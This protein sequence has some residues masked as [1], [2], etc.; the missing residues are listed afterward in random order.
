VGLQLVST[1][2]RG[3]CGRQRKAVGWPGNITGKRGCGLYCGYERRQ[4]CGGLGGRSC[5]LNPRP[6]RRASA[7]LN[8][9]L[10]TQH[11][12]VETLARGT[13]KPLVLS[14]RDGPITRPAGAAPALA[15]ALAVARSLTQYHWQCPWRR[16]CWVLYSTTRRV[17]GSAE[18]CVGTMI[19]VRYGVF[20]GCD[21]TV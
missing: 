13:T 4:R 12:T 5:K 2:A 3:H 19:P 20:H 15:V 7:C 8:V 16:G 21:S 17:N 1:R 10:Q 18:G 9:R 11:S 6:Q 14:N